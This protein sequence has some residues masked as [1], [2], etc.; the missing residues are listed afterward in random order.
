MSVMI[1][2]MIMVSIV[3]PL[4]ALSLLLEYKFKTVSKIVHIMERGNL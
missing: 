3:A 2:L 4:V 1:G